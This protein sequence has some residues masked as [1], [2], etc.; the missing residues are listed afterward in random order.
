MDSSSTRRYNGTGLGLAIVREYAEMHGG[1]V[2]VESELGQG[3]SFVVR[4]PVSGPVSREAAEKDDKSDS[5]PSGED[6]PKGTIMNR[7]IKVM[8]IDDDPGIHES[9]RAVI[10]E[11][12]Y[13]FCGALGGR[14]GLRLLDDERPDLLLLDVMMPGMEW[15]RCLP[16]NA[17]GRTSY[18][19]YLSHGEK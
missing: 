14:E 11:A 9:L 16:T 6:L 5:E 19:R 17:R 18:S 4:I 3:A 10:E 13:E 12:G 15:L 2:S 7:P 8:L 1:S